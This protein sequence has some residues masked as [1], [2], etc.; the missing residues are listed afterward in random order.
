MTLLAML[1]VA[2]GVLVLRAARP[3]RDENVVLSPNWQDQAWYQLDDHDSIALCELPAGAKYRLVIGCLGNS[4][5]ECTV[6]LRLAP[7]ADQP[8]QTRRANVPRPFRHRS[9]A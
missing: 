4:A 9:W 8:T 5:E 3:E 1:L 2:S 7:S 6:K